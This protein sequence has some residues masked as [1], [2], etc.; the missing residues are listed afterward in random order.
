MYIAE[1]YNLPVMMLVANTILAIVS[2]WNFGWMS[3]TMHTLK[4]PSAVNMAYLF[5]VLLS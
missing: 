3:V 2:E 5:Y 1:E 4:C